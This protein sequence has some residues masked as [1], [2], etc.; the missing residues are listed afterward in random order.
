MTFEDDAMKFSREQRRAHWN[1]IKLLLLRKVLR[2]FFFFSFLSSLPLHRKFLDNETTT[3]FCDTQH[4]IWDTVHIE[5]IPRNDRNFRFG[6][7][8]PSRRFPTAI[9]CSHDL[10]NARGM[11]LQMLLKVHR[12]RNCVSFVCSRFSSLID[13]PPLSFPLSQNVIPHGENG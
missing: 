1:L 9:P 2:T 5:R 11:P 3:Y 13:N 6:N 7:F 4:P 8:H 10:Q 12:P